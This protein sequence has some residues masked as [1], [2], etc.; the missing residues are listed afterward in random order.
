MKP[1]DAPGSDSQKAFSK[2]KV[3]RSTGE[4]NTGIYIKE[5]AL[6]TYSF[7]LVIAFLNFLPSQRI[8]KFKSSWTIPVLRQSEKSMQ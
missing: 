8:I 7:I 6:F 1:P 2:D 5:I 3:R 4:V